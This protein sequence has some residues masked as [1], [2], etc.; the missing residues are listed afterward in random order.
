[1]LNHTPRFYGTNSNHFAG[2]FI[3]RLDCQIKQKSFTKIVV[4]A[5]TAGKTL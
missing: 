4:A 3:E 1:M 5:S 2:N